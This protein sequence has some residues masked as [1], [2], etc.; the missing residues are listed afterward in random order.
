VNRHPYR[1][2]NA[3]PRALLGRTGVRIAVLLILVGLVAAAIYSWRWSPDAVARR[4]LASIE[5]GRVVAIVNGTPVKAKSDSAMI[6]D[7]L[8]ALYKLANDGTNMPRDRIKAERTQVIELL[9]KEEI[10][11]QKLAA[12][13][14]TVS[15]AAVDDQIAIVITNSFSGNPTA[16]DNWMVESGYNRASYREGVRTYLRTVA[17]M[18]QDMQ[19]PDATIED[20]RRHYTDHS[21]DF[22]VAER[23]TVKH[24][25]LECKAETSAHEQSNLVKRLRDIRREI[26]KGL[27]FEDAAVKYSECPSRTKGGL[28]GTIAAD[29]EKGSQLIRHAVFATRLSNVSDVV[30]TEYGFH[31]FY[32][33]DKMPVHTARFDQVQYKLA[34]ALTDKRR[35]NAFVNWFGKL[36]SEA[37]VELK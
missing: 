35:Q 22:I 12:S 2:V 36:R 31:L 34:N 30:A 13:T 20:A 26:S 27:K 16:L 15:E 5:Q 1:S 18:Q 11:R 8:M 9:V 6:L 33:V 37:T 14:V 7:R 3:P 28:I 23:A 32:V 17:L 29:G 21:N 25:L 19:P 24:I 4:T 10:V